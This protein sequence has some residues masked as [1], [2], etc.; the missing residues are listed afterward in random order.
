MWGHEWWVAWVRRPES[1]NPCGQPAKNGP[2]QNWCLAL[3]GSSR[4][5]CSWG[6]R[7][8][9]GPRC[10]GWRW[11]R[12][13]VWRGCACSGLRR[14]DEACRGERV[15]V[16]VHA[17]ACAQK[18]GALPSS[19]N[20]TSDLRMS[21]AV[22]SVY[23]PPLYQL[24]YRRVHTGGAGS[25]A[26]VQMGAA[27]WQVLSRGG[28]PLQLSAFHPREPCPAPPCPALPRQAQSLPSG[29][30]TNTH[31][32]THARTHTH[33]RTHFN[34]HTPLQHGSPW[35]PAEAWHAR[36][37]AGTWPGGD[38]QDPHR[39]ARRA[40]SS[41]ALALLPRCQTSASRLGPGSRRMALRRPERARSRA[42]G[43]D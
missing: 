37:L 29:P 30:R 8:S 17:C 12:W 43:G 20:R 35:Y 39:R 4:Q 42:P 23:S 14:Q 6:A 9:W 32:R 24:S 13:A 5:D 26:F 3:A 15:R 21:T 31:A 10:K 16:C 34:A 1:R 18:R 36:D 33:P 41:R 27:S 11:K 40:L 25:S 38:H 7:G 2:S 19:R 22:C 28:V